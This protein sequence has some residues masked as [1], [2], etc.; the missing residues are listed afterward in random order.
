MSKLEK[1]LFIE[2]QIY[3]EK[4]CIM[5]KR[6]PRS[7]MDKTYWIGNMVIMEGNS[8]GDVQFE[9]DRMQ[10]IGRGHSVKNPDVIQKGKPLSNASGSVLDPAMSIQTLV[11]IEPGATFRASFITALS[12]RNESLRTLIEKY[13]NPYVVEGAFRLALTKSQL[14]HRYLNL[15][16][17][18]V[19]LFQ[20]ML[21]HIIFMSPTKKAF[22]KII[23]KNQRGQ[24]SLWRYGIS[25]DFPIILLVL[26]K[27]DQIEILCEALKAHEY[28]SSLDLKIDLVVLNEE[29][30]SYNMPLCRLIR[31]MI[32]SKQTNPILDQPG[33]IFIL[34]KNTMD[35]EDIYL[36]HDVARIILMGDQGSMIDQ[37]EDLPQEDVQHPA[38]AI[39]IQNEKPFISS[40]KNTHLPFYNGL[41]GFSAAGNE[42]II[43]LN[44]EQHTP[45]PWINVIANPSFGFITSEAGSGFTWFENSHEY[46]LTPWSNDAVSDPPGEVIYLMDNDTEQHWTVTPLPIRENESYTIR[47]GFG[48]TVF[49]HHSHQIDQSLVQ[50]VP[51]NDP[52]KISLL[53]LTNTSKQEKHLTLTYY[54][55]PILGVNDQE[56]AMFIQTKTN[57][58]GTLI[59]K[60]P[61]NVQFA[62]ILTFLDT[63]IRERTLTGD[64]K[65][66]F[67]FGDDRRPDELFKKELSGALGIGFDPCGVI[68][69]K[70]TLLPEE[71]K[72]VVLLLG[73]VSSKQQLHELTHKYRQANQ[74][75]QALS[76]VQASWHNTINTLQVDTPADSV[77]IMLNGW[78]PYQ[79]ISC[80]LWAR[81]GFY[82]SGGAFGFRDQL[83][84]CISIAHISPEIARAQILR[85]AGRQFEEGDVQ[86]W[87]HEPQGIGIRTRCSD[88]MLWLPYATAEY[89][90]I[91]GDTAILHEKIPFLVDTPLE[92]S[93]I[94]RFSSPQSTASTFS[95]F[96]HCI[97]AIDHSF[98]WGAHDLPL[99]GSGD[100]N[101]GMSTVGHKGQ[102]ESVWLGWFLICILKKFAPICETHGEE[103]RSKLYSSTCDNLLKAIENNAWD[104]NWYLRAFFDDGAPLGSLQNKECK[105]DSIAQTW[106][107]ISGSGN[108]QRAKTA[109]N[110][111]EDYLISREDGLIKLITPPFYD[112]KLEPG[113]IK[114]YLPG[115][116]EN[117]GQYTHAA[118]WVI[119]AFAL[120]GD[121]DKAWELFELINPINH[122]QNLRECAHYK[123]EPYVM[124]ADVYSSFPNKGRGGWSWYTGSA[125]WIYR[126]GL[127]YILGFQ[128]NGD[129]VT[130]DPC[131][132]KEWKEYTIHYQFHSSSYHIQVKNPHGICKG[133]AS[134]TLDGI[135][136]NSNCFPLTNDRKKHHIIVTMGS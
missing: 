112:S 116:R 118:A 68:Q 33:G 26:H 72:E 16:E 31:E 62:D 51:K 6:R 43:Q 4:N 37:I 7:E 114:G 99:I 29:E 98:K 28:W 82:Q 93:E 64:R 115:V 66:F 78:I 81:S 25:G 20:N 96:E 18:E 2:T 10:M 35:M 50:F 94:D 14:E 124:A 127:E 45:A 117:G 69:V 70:L 61:Y 55:R 132:P 38:Q 120:L 129:S 12:H 135:V 100:W 87:W 21:S 65:E 119:I 58:T 83:Q 19:V 125:G 84:D 108:H 15:S 128:K 79:V 39:T 90:R 107:I 3:P 121:G 130:M 89:I 67:G 11:K 63:S 49:E 47:H 77:N 59:M 75:K 13:S 54:V 23:Q 80:R 1:N 104:G 95:L 102:G 85:H 44:Q 36:L 131:I 71:S 9:T 113:Y 57:D 48:Y 101:D 73:A 40:P 105:I 46:K 5:A 123:L 134:I 8:I 86:H 91:T 17:T 60:N 126:A 103:D 41:G 106:A 109:M 74:A 111:L 30:F 92:D 27:T 32:L 22:E 133:V 34:N 122:T 97:R 53:S 52:V 88:D 56:T 24:S 76:K 136:Q 110:S 42:Y